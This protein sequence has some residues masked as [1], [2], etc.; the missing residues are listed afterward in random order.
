MKERNIYEEIAIV[1]LLVSIM[2]W[3]ILLAD[4]ILESRK[5][6]YELGDLRIE[7]EVLNQILGKLGDG[8]RVSLCSIEKNK[9]ATIT[10]RREE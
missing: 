6:Y 5:E 9:C 2:L 1:L 10:I 7:K 8:E 3:G 4:Y